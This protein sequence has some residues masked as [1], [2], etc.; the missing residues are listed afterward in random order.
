M[1]RMNR[2]ILVPYLQDVCALQLT[3]KKQQEKLAKLHSEKDSALREA[4]VA[5]PTARATVTSSFFGKL[6]CVGVTSV[7]C[8]LILAVL[9]GIMA[10]LTGSIVG[11]DSGSLGDVLLIGGA[12]VAV[13]SFVLHLFSISI[14]NA[15]IMRENQ[16]N[17]QSW[18]KQSDIRRSKAEAIC[19]GISNE[20]REIESQI[21]AVDGLLNKAYSANLIPSRYRDLYAAVYLYDWFSTG[22]S[23]D[24]DMALNTYVLE[25]IKSRLDTIIQNQAVQIINQRT[26]IANQARMANAI[27]RNAQQMREKVARMNESLEKQNM[28]LNMIDSN[29]AATRYF[30]EEV[31]KKWN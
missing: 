3:K 27:E 16:Q 28:Y 6:A 13:V 12:I 20:I 5:M 14:Q 21:H 2:E 11:D 31:Y 25:Q 29:V 7:G 17:F 10:G 23:D 26:I 4:V 24:M 8:S 1:A 18:K 30:A 22:M 9:V 19:A 15:N